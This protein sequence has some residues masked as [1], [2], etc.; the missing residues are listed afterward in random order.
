MCQLALSAMKKSKQ[1]FKQRL[2]GIREQSRPLNIW[3]ERENGCWPVRQEHPWCVLK[4]TG[5]PVWPD[6]V[7]QGEEGWESPGAQCKG[8]GF[9]SEWSRETLKEWPYGKPVAVTSLQFTCG[10]QRG[11]EGEA[12]ELLGG[13]C[14]HPGESGWGPGLR[15]WVRNGQMLH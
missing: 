13:H 5:R 11:P 10:E 4:A 15:W 14:C 7:S 3:V 9:C 12:A 6:W 2:T 1:T 8:L